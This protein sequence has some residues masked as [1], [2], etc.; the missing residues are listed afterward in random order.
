MLIHD[1]SVDGTLRESLMRLT[2]MECAI[3]ITSLLHVVSGIP[4]TRQLFSLQS[5]KASR[6]TLDDD[7]ISPRDTN[8]SEC[9]SASVVICESI[10]LVAKASRIDFSLC[11]A[12]FYSQLLSEIENS[13]DNDQSRDVY[14]SSL[15]LIEWKKNARALSALMIN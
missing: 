8:R 1:Q 13:L 15:G 5:D 11:V 14:E 12:H 9:Q 6:E 3:K 10:E 7:A 4:V 2:V